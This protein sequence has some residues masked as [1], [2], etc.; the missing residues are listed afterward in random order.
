MLPSV[1]QDQRELPAVA[2]QHPG[3]GGDLVPTL[4]ET[5]GAADARTH[6][7]ADGR[8]AHPD[9]VDV[10]RALPV[11]EMDAGE[12]GGREVVHVDRAAEAGVRDPHL[13]GATAAARA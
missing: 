11:E 6:A 13:G 3:G 12:V 9:V 8:A 4:V 7:R 2:D 10:G 1:A 5:P